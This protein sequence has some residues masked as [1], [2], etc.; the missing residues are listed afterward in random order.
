MCHYSYNRLIDLAQ[1][2][3]DRLIVHNPIEDQN[4]VIMSV[5]EYEKL[6]DNQGNSG[7]RGFDVRDLSSDQMLDQINRDIAIWRSE[8]EEE[9][10]WNR[11]ITMEDEFSEE[12]PFDPFAE[13]DYHPADWHNHPEDLTG[14]RDPWSRAGS[15]LG[16]RYSDFHED[17]TSELENE[18]EEDDF[19]FGVDSLADAND[20]LE[21]DVELSK[22]E[23]LEDEIKVEDIPFDIDFS[24]IEGSKIDIPFLNQDL[25]GESWDEEPLEDDDE[26]VFYEEPV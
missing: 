12:S 7:F 10:E 1:R 3:G 14:G 22:E 11:E 17:E 16:N 19:D 8:K 2:T 18:I 5:D 20:F 26:P 15:V 24:Q 25:E 13:Q 4:T 23:D 6:L 21:G 9:E